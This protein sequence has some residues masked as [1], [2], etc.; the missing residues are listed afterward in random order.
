MR[1]THVHGIRGWASPVGTGTPH[2]PLHGHM[3]HADGPSSCGNCVTQVLEEM[4]ISI[5]HEQWVAHIVMREGF[6]KVLFAA[7]RIKSLLRRVRHHKKVRL[8]TKFQ[9]LWRAHCIRQRWRARLIAVGNVRKREALCK[10][11]A[12]NA[13]AAILER[14]RKEYA[15]AKWAQLR[16]AIFL[17]G[18]L[19]G[20]LAALEERREEARL[21]A[22]EAARL[23]AEA[24]A[25][26]REE[27]EMA[28]QAALV[29]LDRVVVAEAAR[30]LDVQMMK[31]EMA[32][33][34]D[35]LAEE[36]VLLKIAEEIE[37]RRKAE[38]A[39]KLKIAMRAAWKRAEVEGQRLA[40]I[41]REKEKDRLA[42]LWAA[43]F[44]ADLVETSVQDKAWEDSRIASAAADEVRVRAEA[45]AKQ[46]IWEECVRVAKGVLTNVKAFQEREFE[47]EQEEERIRRE[48]EKKRRREAAKARIFKAKSAASMSLNM[49]AI[50]EDAEA[51]RV[52]QAEEAERQAQ[53]AAQFFAEDVMTSVIEKVL[54]D[55][56]EE[57][58]AAAAAQAAAEFM[59]RLMD[60]VYIEKAEE[61]A[62]KLLAEAKAAEEAANAASQRKRDIKRR[63]QELKEEAARKAAEEAAAKEEAELVAREAAE[64]AELEAAAKAQAEEAERQAKLEQEEVDRSLADGKKKKKAAKDKRDKKEQVSQDKLKDATSSAA[65]AKK[66]ANDASKTARNSSAAAKAKKSEV[67]YREAV[68]DEAKMSVETA[69]AKAGGAAAAAYDPVEVEP[70]AAE[71]EP[72]PP[73]PPPPEKEITSMGVLHKELRK[74]LFDEYPYAVFQSWDTDNSGKIEKPELF[75]A[76]TEHM[77]MNVAQSLCDALFD[78]F[79]DDLS[80]I[81]DYQELYDKLA[82]DQKKPP[83][84]LKPKAVP[85]KEELES[86][87]D[88]AKR[89]KKEA[90]DKKKADALAAAAAKKAAADE[91]RAEAVAA[92]AAKKSA[93]EQKK[94]QAKAQAAE[95]KAEEEKKKADAVVQTSQKK[96][97]DES[98]RAAAAAAAA[99]LKAEKKQKEAKAAKKKAAEDKKKDME[100]EETAKEAQEKTAEAERKVKERKAAAAAAA[101]EKAAEIERKKTEK[102]KEE[103]RQVAEKAQ[104]VAAKAAEIE[105]RRKD[106]QEAAA[107]AVAARALEQEQRKAEAAELAARRAAL[108]KEDDERRRAERKATQEKAVQEA[109][110]RKA[111]KERSPNRTR[112]PPKQ[113]P[114]DGTQETILTPRSRVR[115][116][117]AAIETHRRLAE[118]GVVGSE[119]VQPLR[120]HRGGESINTDTERAAGLP[121]A[122]SFPNPANQQMAW[123]P[124]TGKPPG[125]SQ[126]AA[127]GFF[128]PPMLEEVG[129]NLLLQQMSM[130]PPSGMAASSLY[131]LPDISSAQQLPQLRSGHIPQAFVEGGPGPRIPPGAAR[132]GPS[133]TPGSAGRAKPRQG[134]GRP[135]AAPG[136]APRV[137]EHPRSYL[138]PTE[139]TDRITRLRQQHAAM[140][141]VT[142]GIGNTLGSMPAQRKMAPSSSAP[143]LVPR[144][145]TGYGTGLERLLSP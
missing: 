52:R 124:S 138:P 30:I 68:A 144:A 116:E 35:F 83:K 135:P 24:E 103:E 72:P 71:E 90:E 128:L 74:R 61:D 139:L 133:R 96:E 92:A 34:I 21:A 130:L 49:M 47:R 41:E 23:E 73:P 60:T 39:R 42:A 37:A 40:A 12:T 104:K 32:D 31:E 106:R 1:H 105:Q 132:Q 126:R 11:T 77:H 93:D 70:A 26:R 87:I 58:A 89:K 120:A 25:K 63:Q 14:T 108:K 125:G 117:I 10:A 136:S 38:E 13:V 81:L 50:A 44:A 69:E 99:R 140:G 29:E 107:A 134:F 142:Q 88:E 28:W 102:Q 122:R 118:L 7:M 113:K 64:A 27:E 131:N 8:V 19:K 6:Q 3:R 123:M 100:K 75:K 15:R 62:M 59:A 115:A 111:A 67:I 18:N 43:E 86:P 78:F 36:V 82:R 4:S 137:M 109:A 95:R 85:K 55:K 51:E 143:Q 127:A 79:D 114:E 57:E 98:K 20:K 145:G 112:T 119:P 45:L 141:I 17:A 54:A 56:K 53:E 101:A 48:E 16:T 65:S 84:P 46:R 121:P 33:F 22:V 97:A 80:G 110:A 66:K 5:A 129:T 2:V 91:K 94:A 76:V 9:N